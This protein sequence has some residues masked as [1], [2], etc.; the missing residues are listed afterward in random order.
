MDALYF[1][2]EVLEA[3]ADIIEGYCARQKAI[4]DD[5]LKNMSALSSEWTDDQT[6]GTLLDEIVKM[7]LDVTAVME[8]IRK[9]YPR[10]FREKA[11]QIRNRPKF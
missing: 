4:M 8:E 7:R 11:E 5:Y 2:P 6:L 10:F 9:D 1:D 3:T